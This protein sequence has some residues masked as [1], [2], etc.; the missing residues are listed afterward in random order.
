[1]ATSNR[2][3]TGYFRQPVVETVMCEEFSPAMGNYIQKLTK[4]VRSSLEEDIE[5]TIT[6]QTSRALISFFGNSGLQHV[7][8]VK[9]YT[10]KNIV[11]ETPD[12]PRILQYWEAVAYASQ[13]IRANSS[14][15]SKILSRKL[16]KLNDN[17][18][19]LFDFLKESVEFAPGSEN[20][21]KFSKDFQ[22]KA[23]VL[24]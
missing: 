12:T 2:L 4:D 11:I 21:Q 22:E 20:A 18:E 17:F 6:Y 8:S 5:V 3:Y 13:V 24:P 15:S 7:L 1:M 14:Y 9:E 10:N 16:D 23:R 19:K